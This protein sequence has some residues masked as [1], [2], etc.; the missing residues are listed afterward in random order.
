MYEDLGKRF[1]NMCIQAHRFK[2]Q[3]T[4]VVGIV[5]LTLTPYK[6]MKVVLWFQ[7]D[8]R[9]FHTVNYYIS[10]DGMHEIVGIPDR[11]VSTDVH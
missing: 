5:G 3:Q 4:G 2:K 11:K 9:S 10:K 8:L 7:G 1:G 6:C